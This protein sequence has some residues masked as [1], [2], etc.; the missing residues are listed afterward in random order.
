MRQVYLLMA[1][2]FA[3]L[4]F[5]EKNKHAYPPPPSYSYQ[6]E[7]TEESQKPFLSSLFEGL[8][9]S[10]RE[11]TVG[12]SDKKETKK[13]TRTKRICNFRTIRG[14]STFH[15]VPPGC[16]DTKA[17]TFTPLARECRP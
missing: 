12:D 10:R 13:R 4:Y 15:E 3:F 14:D 2:I 11:R 8:L 5:Q 6:Q 17:R 9:G 16:V 7:A 1:I